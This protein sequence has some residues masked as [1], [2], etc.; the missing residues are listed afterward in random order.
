M[1]YGE[2]A[3]DALDT[4]R[5]GARAARERRVVAPLALAGFS[6]D[7]IRERSRARG[8]PTS[9]KA[10]FA[11]LSSRFPKGSRLSIE[12][13]LKVERAEQILRNLGF[14]QYRARHHGDL[15]RIEVEEQDFIRL[16]DAQAR[17]TLLE[18]L[19]AVGYRHIT[20]DLAGYRTGSTA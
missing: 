3:D 12:E 20:L 10:S 4:T 9:E 2:M 19:R 14:H 1:A 5:L 13:M 11:C 6:K 17:R 7:D 16:I 18:G 15:C 8:L